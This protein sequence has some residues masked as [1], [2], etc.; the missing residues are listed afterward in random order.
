MSKGKSVIATSFDANHFQGA[1]MFLF[2]RLAIERSFMLA[3]LDSI[4]I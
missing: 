2:L 4:E 3:T 1:V